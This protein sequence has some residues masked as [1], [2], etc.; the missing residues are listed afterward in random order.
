MG[1]R[2]P[3]GGWVL[4]QIAGLS[5][6]AESSVEARRALIEAGL[7][8]DE[9][10]S[11]GLQLVRSLRHQY[12]PTASD[13]YQNVLERFL[14]RA[15]R[16]FH[17]PWWA[18]H[19]ALYLVTDVA[20]VRLF[21]LHQLYPHASNLAFWS[22]QVAE[23]MFTTYML[24]HLRTARALADYAAA[25]IEDGMFR[26][27]WLNEYVAPSSQG[28]L[29]QWRGLRFTV[30]SSL[31]AL[32]IVLIYYGGQLLHFRLG[33]GSIPSAARWWAFYYPYP[34]LLY[35]YPTIAK[36]CM[37]VAGAGYFW[38]LR[39]VTKLANGQFPSKLNQHERDELYARCGEAATQL[40][41]FVTLATLIWLMARYLTYI[42]TPTL[43]AYLYSS[44]LIVLFITEV[45]IFRRSRPGFHAGFFRALIAPDFL[46]AQFSGVRRALA[47][48]A[49]WGLIIICPQPLAQ[50]AVECG[51]RFG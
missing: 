1:D 34:Q 40:T 7:D 3:D 50:L 15:G 44:W 18:V 21:E 48:S 51:V 30:R 17:L 39:G 32:A 42:H 36:A 25:S 12:F 49:L 37:M 9:I 46:F 28:W 5:S 29:V 23:F 2:R 41:V 26:H 6:E 38:W 11:R 33:F 24:W 45:L 14:E 4:Q 16:F 35:L 8:P 19:L 10:T 31:A 20:F 13:I 43:W 22:E 47:I 27:R